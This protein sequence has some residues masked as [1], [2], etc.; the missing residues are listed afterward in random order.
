M[1]ILQVMSSLN[2][3]GAETGMMHVL[4]HID[5]QKYQTDFL[6][7]TT[8]LAH[9]DDEAKS[10]GA[11]IIPCCDPDNPLR[12]AFDLRRILCQYGPYDCVHSH[13]HQLSGLVLAVAAA[14]H[15]P[16]RI[17]HARTD[18]SVADGGGFWWRKA[19][20]RM[21]ATMIRR[22]ANRGLA[23]SEEAANS[24]FPKNWKDH[25]DW[26]VAPSGIDLRQFDE[27][28]DPFKVRAELG[29]PLRTHIVG[30]VGRFVDA[31]NHHFL[32][33]I[34]ASLFPKDSQAL[35]LLVG[36]GPLRS[37]TEN[38]VRSRGLSK[39][40]I[41][42]G[43]RGDIPRILRGAMDCFVLP[44]TR[45][46]LPMAL[47]EAQAAGLHCVVSTAVSC[48]GDIG[49]CAVTRV[50]LSQSAEVWA[51]CLQEAISR[52]RRFDIPEDWKRRRSIEH[53]AKAIEDV[54]AS[55]GGGAPMDTDASPRSAQPS[56]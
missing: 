56:T 1:R 20:I 6:V 22:F 15:V 23:V 12:Y 48:E 47:L 37:E 8:N 33:D 9:Y 34:A 43:I 3:G 45:E 36:D 13:V 28:L 27:P 35:F 52:S 55:L 40:F 32:V 25:S 14:E 53:C 19:Y 51:R 38:L 42:A 11:R 4:R 29:I 21:M 2:R 24:L 39:R 26:R 50:P 10:L 49:R 31:K 46:G 18:T 54:Y 44:S 30:H 16:L 17:V 7:H 5:R 41:F